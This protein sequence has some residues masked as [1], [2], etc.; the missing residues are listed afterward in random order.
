[1]YFMKINKTSKEIKFRSKQQKTKH[2][3]RKVKEEDGKEYLQRNQ[4][5]F[6]I[7][8]EL[9]SSLTS[10]MCKILLMWKW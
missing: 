4:N 7:S 3:Y 8:M 1:M 6:L 2:L 10:Q 9:R 5:H